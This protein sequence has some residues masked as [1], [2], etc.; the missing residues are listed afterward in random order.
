MLASEAR[1]SVR[2]ASALRD[3]PPLSSQSPFLLALLLPLTSFLPSRQAVSS[4]SFA[5]SKFVSCLVTL[6]HSDPPLPWCP[7]PW[8][9]STLIATSQLNALPGLS[10]VS[11]TLQW[12]SLAFRVKSQLS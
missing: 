3:E 4:S 8:F 11:E 12:H 2:A 5:Y 6:P 1:Y 9:V 10:L 7:I